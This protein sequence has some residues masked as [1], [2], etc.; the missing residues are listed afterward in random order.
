[1][2]G[3]AARARA[4][5]DVIRQV[6]IGGIVATK[7]RENG[8]DRYVRGNTVHDLS[9]ARRGQTATR[10]RQDLLP[11]FSEDIDKTRHT[12]KTQIQ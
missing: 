7:T 8:H 4:V 11:L 12:K 5:S 3:R 6:T 2:L 1:M 10:P 9:E